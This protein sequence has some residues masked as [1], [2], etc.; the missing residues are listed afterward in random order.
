MD[1]FQYKIARTSELRQILA[2]QKVEADR[3]CA[4]RVD[5]EKREELI[6][7]SSDWYFVVMEVRGSLYCTYCNVT[8]CLLCCCFCP[9][10]L[11]LF[12]SLE[13]IHVFLLIVSCFFFPI[14]S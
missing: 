8:L 13:A 5:N 1:A 10:D 7:V 3:E 11:V 14:I 4:I 6:L 9:Y 12:R 2:R